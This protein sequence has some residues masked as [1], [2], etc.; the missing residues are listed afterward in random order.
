MTAS[1]DWKARWA[2][3]LLVATATVLLIAG[4]KGSASGATAT[5][6][7]AKQVDIDHFAFHPPT[8]TVKQ[9]A[10]VAFVNSSRVA[11]TATRAGSFNT[12]HIKPGTSVVV[13]FEHKGTFS[14]HCEIHPFMKGK[15]VVE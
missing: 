3:V 10:R 15:I 12:G 7:G 11:H 9:G 5:A 1:W 8:L 2:F 14:Y 13:R 4:D 6:S